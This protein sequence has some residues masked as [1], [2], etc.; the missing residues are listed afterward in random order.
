MQ[1]LSIQ[2]LVFSLENGHCWKI[3]A[4]VATVLCAG[5]SVPSGRTGLRTRRTLELTSE[6]LCLVLVFN[7]QL[8]VHNNW[9]NI[10]DNHFKKAGENRSFSGVRKYVPRT[11]GTY[12]PVEVYCRIILKEFLLVRMCIKQSIPN[13]LISPIYNVKYKT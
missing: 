1:F 8:Q 2:D 3:C 6:A 7:I 10:T 5:R 9:Q 12:E 13:N 11:L 4:A